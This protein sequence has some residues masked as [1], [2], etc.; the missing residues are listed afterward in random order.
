M[1]CWDTIRA[2]KR[3]N[4]REYVDKS[5]EDVLNYQSSYI[6]N[7][8][9]GCTSSFHSD[10]TKSEKK[11]FELFLEGVTSATLDNIEFSHI[12]YRKNWHCWDLRFISCEVEEDMGG[13]LIF[14]N[15]KALSKSIALGMK[16]VFTLI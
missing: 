6:I 5:L 16:Q 1:E 8:I 13:D 12:I 2:G 15:P 14:K 4:G 3:W 7:S 9:D 10:L 11:I